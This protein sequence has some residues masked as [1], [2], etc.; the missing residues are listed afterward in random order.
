MFDQQEQVNE[1]VRDPITG[2]D[3]FS[4]RVAEIHTLG[5]ESWKRIGCAP[6]STK[7][8]KLKFPSYLNGALHWLLMDSNIS[9][10]IASFN[11]DKEI[12]QPIPLPPLGR[13]MTGWE[14]ETMKDIV[15]GALKDRLCIC[16]HD[17]VSFEIEVWVMKKYGVKKSW[18][19]VFR[20][21]TTTEMSRW[22]HVVYEPIS[23]LRNGSI[24]FFH[25]LA[26]AVVCYNAKG[27]FSSLKFLKIRGVK[28]K[29]EAIAYTPSFISLNNAVM[30]DNLATLNVASRKPMKR[31]RKPRGFN[32]AEAFPLVRS[33]SP[34][35][36]SRNLYLVEPPEH[37]SGFD[38]RE[39][40]D[41]YGH[42]LSGRHFHMKL[43]TKLKIPLRNAE[44]AMNNEGV[45]KVSSN[46]KGGVKRKRCIKLRP[47]DHKLNLVNS[48]H[49]FL[50][51]S[52]PSRNDP[53]VVCNPITGKFINLPI[54]TQADEKT[55]HVSDCGLGFGP[56]TNHY[57][58]IRIFY[59]QERVY[60]QV[61]DPITGR[62]NY[63]RRVAEIH[64]LGMDSWKRIGCAPSSM[65]GYKLEFPSYLN[66]A[67]HW[68]LKD[69]NIS[70]YIASFNFD[71]EIFQPVPPPP[72]RR[73]IISWETMKNISLGVLRDMLCICDHDSH[74]FKIN[75]WVMEN[76]GV[77][78]SWTKV[79]RIDATT[80]Q[81]RW[82][83]G[84][85]EPISYL[86]S[87]AILFF[88]RLANAVV[89]YKAKGR[90]LKFLKVR[91]V[92]SNY[93]AIAYTPSF[94]SINDKVMGDNLATLNVASSSLFRFC[95]NCFIY[96][97]F[98]ISIG[99][100]KTPMLTMEL[101]FRCAGLKLQGETKALFLREEDEDMDSDFDLSSDLDSSTTN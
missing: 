76:Y 40:C 82:L 26:N 30:R 18:T 75:I 14:W 72:L 11:F 9:E 8:Y 13:G 12:F 55:R 87:G 66:G 22:L 7:G 79:F 10:Y 98:S 101:L 59:Q 77:Q 51:L 41:C 84:V 1:H 92:K 38:L 34:T 4:P 63:S 88:H 2:R 32:A 68:L 74:V 93:E 44:L 100:F 69:Y 17:S 50:C 58:V 28:S 35:H 47:K 31:G 64:T 96:F 94:I 48:C 62:K 43:E 91:G 52:E 70:E 3:S 71:K 67:L 90:F 42:S 37:N 99:L 78:E 24:L 97:V 19:N 36:I 86:R 21:D 89:Y 54:P 60:E 83:R 57:K 81:S 73:G 20:I 61:R 65:Y 46:S 95:P 23:Y 25:R 29:Y 85:Y 5:T 27:R 45:A 80:K 53:V 39:Y 6:S 15:L 49:G 16:H 33:L 56:K